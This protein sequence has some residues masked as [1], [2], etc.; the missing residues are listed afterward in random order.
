LVIEHVRTLI[1]EGDKL[2][3]GRLLDENFN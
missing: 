1:N 2:I 3:K